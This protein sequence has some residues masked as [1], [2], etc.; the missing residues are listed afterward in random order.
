VG[1]PA[2][3]SGNMLTLTGLG[4]VSVQASQGGSNSF[5][6]ASL[7]QTFNVTLGNPAIKS[8]V[9]GAS[10]GAG[11]VPASYY[12]TLFGNN[13][14]SGSSLGDSTRTLTLEGT[15][16]TVVDSTKQT[17]AASIAFMSYG[18]INLVVP[19]GVASGPAS[20]TVTNSTGK[21]ASVPITI[22]A[23]APGVFSADG[24]GTG[25]AAADVVVVAGDGSQTLSS[26]FSCTPFNCSLTPIPVVPGTQAYLV[27]FG[28]GI[29]GRSS[30][31]GVSVTI[32]GSP[33]T[34]TYA[35]PQGSFAGL[36]QIDVLIPASLAGAGIADVKLTADGIAANTVK[37][38]V[39]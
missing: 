13:F 38:N 17:F 35:G 37:I 7:V 3:L 26:A 23:L 29:R 39:R 34:V 27:L 15:T 18:Q 6:P 12:A 14:A 24:T 21:S 16:A 2:A 28:T 20:I 4:T 11:I 33:A 1:G 25:G 22:G 32:G 19:A 31:A 30:L 5:A 9:N 10:F 36:D 8:I